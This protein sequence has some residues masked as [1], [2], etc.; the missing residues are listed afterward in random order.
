[1]PR[2]W[3]GVE[4]HMSYF[5]QIIFPPLPKEEREDKLILNLPYWFEYDAIGTKMMVRCPKCDKIYRYSRLQQDTHPA[6][7]VPGIQE[8]PKF[9]LTEWIVNC[10]HYSIHDEKKMRDLI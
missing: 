8:N 6:E 2:L 1:M 7:I 10:P 5:D 9:F 3:S 4:N